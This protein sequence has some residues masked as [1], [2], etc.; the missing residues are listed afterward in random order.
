MFLVCVVVVLLVSVGLL[1]A[2]LGPGRRK[3]VMATGCEDTKSAAG[4]WD[5]PTKLVISIYA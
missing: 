4:M 5:R 3:S 1:C 2:L